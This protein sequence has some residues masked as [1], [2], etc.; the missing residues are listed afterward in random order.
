MNWK[1]ILC[2]TL[3]ASMI[4]SASIFCSAAEESAS[5]KLSRI[6]ID[7]YGSEQSGAI[8]D[9]I[10]RLEKSY[11]G[12]NTEGNMNARIE[13]IYDNLYDNSEDV[14]VFVKIGL[15]E[16]NVNHE[17]SGG[18]LDKRLVALENQI[19]GKTTEGTFEERI[20]ELSKATFGEENLPLSQVQ[21]PANTLIKIVTTAPVSSKVLQTNDAV[22]FK[23]ADDVFVN[24]NLV[25]AKGLAGEGIVAEVHHAK[26]I[27]SN[28]KID[29]DFHKLR[30]IDG[31]EVKTFAGVEAI[32]AM[33]KNSMS[34]GL[35]L[36]G[37]N[38]S[39]KHGGVVGEVFN[40]G[41][42]VD[43]PEG[44]ELYVQIEEPVIV[45]G[46]K[47][48][49]EPARPAVETPPLVPIVEQPPAQP[50]TETVIFDET[51]NKPKEET[52]SKTEEETKPEPPKENTPAPPD[53]TSEP[54]R[55]EGKTLEGFDGEIIEIIDED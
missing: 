47:V 35:S 42:N 25:F 28:G 53:S 29:V 49:D 15:L 50:S 33:S 12:E 2:G 41:K 19:M 24:G 5:A 21:I 34:Q 46:L 52:T 17:I 26:N 1:K 7:T 13:A 22:P 37:Q 38:S 45:H 4:F 20:R 44:V 54:R 36:I 43:L 27:F 39:G 32:D 9:R 55:E 51:D 23:V 40:R 48:S 18:G 10:S 30:A 14:G 8:L 3:A 31:Q 16:W 6:E 11:N